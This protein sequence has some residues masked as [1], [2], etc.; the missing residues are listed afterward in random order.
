MATIDP[1]R[2]DSLLAA[3]NKKVE[4]LY[5]KLKASESE[6]ARKLTIGMLLYFRG[7]VATGY[8]WLSL[9]FFSIGGAEKE[10]GRF[11]RKESGFC[12]KRK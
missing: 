4:I 1:E 5:H 6:H 3:L 8:I 11:D 7:S 2:R 10:L 9:F 12:S